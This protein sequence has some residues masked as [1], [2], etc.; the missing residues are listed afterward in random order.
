MRPA[1]APTTTPHFD[2][3]TELI[4]G[5]LRKLERQLK[6]VIINV[7]VADFSHGA[8][9]H[10][11]PDSD[12]D[13]VRCWNHAPQLRYVPFSGTQ[14]WRSVSVD[15]R[16]V[17]IDAQSLCLLRTALLQEHSDLRVAVVSEVSA[18]RL[19]RFVA[20]ALDDIA[21]HSRAAHSRV[22]LSSWYMQDWSPARLHR[23]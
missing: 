22:I 21:D 10:S 3:V 9:C 8:P 17:F 4:V 13:C 20:R 7:M 15:A 5:L 23:M 19:R 6:R 18:D 16:A 14:T 1:Q 11:A 12:V 2:G